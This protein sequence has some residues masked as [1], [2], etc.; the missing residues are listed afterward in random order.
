MSISKFAAVIDGLD[1]STRPKR[2]HAMTYI[3]SALEHIRNEEEAYLAR[4][5]E[6]FQNG[7]AYAA[8]DDSISIVSDAIDSLLDAY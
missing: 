3:I 7:E 2:R 8:A 5:P 4:I 1:L 6:N